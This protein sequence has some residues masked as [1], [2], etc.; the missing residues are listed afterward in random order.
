ML[1]D[2][3]AS[4]YSEYTLKE[5]AKMLRYGAENVLAK[6]AGHFA[7]FNAPQIFR[8]YGMCSHDQ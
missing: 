4:N 6:A 8:L 2:G 5:K 3:L 1:Q 7:K